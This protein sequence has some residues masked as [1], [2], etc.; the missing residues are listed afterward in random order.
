MILIKQGSNTLYEVNNYTYTESDMGDANITLKLSVPVNM[1]VVELGKPEVDVLAP[2]F[3]LDWFVEEK[4]EKFYLTTEKP[5]GTKST[6]S[7]NYVY[8]LIFNSERSALKKR[9][10]K[11]LASL[12][13]DTFISQGL[14]FNLMNA[15]LS[16]FAQLIQK[17]L[18]DC[19]GSAWVIDIN[20]EIISSVTATVLIEISNTYIWDLLLKTYEYYGVRWTIQSINGVMTIRVGYDPVEISHIF[21]YG[22]ENG[23]TT[24]TRQITDTKV[25]NRLRGTGGTRNLPTNYFT[26][27]Y[28]NFEPDPDAIAGLFAFKNLMPKCFRDSVKL[29]NQDNTKP[30][31]DYVTLPDIPEY[32]VIEDG[33]DSNEDIYPSIEGVTIAGLGRIDEIVDVEQTYFDDPE[34]KNGIGITGVT[35]TADV[36][37]GKTVDN[38]TV[39]EKYTEPFVITDAKNV[40]CDLNLQFLDQY[41]NIV[42]PSEGNNHSYTFTDKTNKQIT[43]SGTID[44]I[45]VSAQL[46]R[47]SD[48]AVVQTDTITAI[49]TVKHIQYLNLAIGSYKIKVTTTA[50]GNLSAKPLNW[51]AFG[52]KWSAVGIVTSITNVQGIYKSTFDIW[53]KDI[54]FDLAET[55]TDGISKYAGT[56]DGLITFKSG[57]LAG[58]D[59]KIMKVS[60]VSN[61]FACYPDTS[62]SLDGVQSKY[63][64]TLIKNDTEYQAGSLMLPNVAVRALPADQFAI[65]DINMP[66]SYVTT[67]EARLQSYLEEQLDIISKLYPTYTV[68]LLDIFLQLNPTIA[69]DLRGG[70]KCRIQDSRLTTGDMSLYIN[71]VTI[72][73]TGILPKYT[74]TVTDKIT[75]NGSTVQRISAQIDAISAGIYTG[76]LSTAMTVANLDKRFLRKNIEDTAYEEIDFKGGLKAT[77]I[78][79]EDFQQ[80]QFAGKGMGVFKDLSGETVIEVD[81][82]TVRNTATFNEVVINQIKFQGGIVVYSLANMEVSRVDGMTLYFDMKG[83]SVQNQ[84]VLDD[85]VRCQRWVSGV[86]TKDY[87][88]IVTDVGVDYIT[89][90]SQV[91]QGTIDASVGDIV[92][93]FGNI[94]N[95]DRR[96]AIEVNVLNGGRQTFYQDLGVNPLLPFDTTNKNVIDIGNVFDTTNQFSTTNKWR[97]VI[98]VYGDAY[99]GAR[100]MSSY[101][102]FNKDGELEIKAN[103]L[104]KGL[105]GEYKE[106]S[107]IDASYLIDVIKKGTSEI[108]GGLALANV[109]AVKD[110]NGNITAGI[111][112]VQADVFSIWSGGTYSQAKAG[113]AKV[114]INKDG[115]GYLADHNISW[116]AAG[117]LIMKYAF[118]ATEG[119]IGNFTIFEN[120]IVND[121]IEFSDTEI[122]SL[123]SLINPVDE[124]INRVASWTAT[125]IHYATAFTQALTTTK[126]GLV[127]VAVFANIDGA[128]D[129]NIKYPPISS[130]F[131]MHS[132]EFKLTVWISNE[133]NETVITTSKLCRDDGCASIEIAPVLPAGVYIIHALAE[134]F[135]FENTNVEIIGNYDNATTGAIIFGGD[136]NVI[137]LYR[138]NNNT[139]IGLDGFYSELDALR[140]FYFKATSGLKVKGAKRFFNDSYR[141][142]VYDN[143]LEPIISNVN[144]YTSFILDR[145]SN[146]STSLR[147][148]HL[149]A[150][151]DLESGVNNFTLKILIGSSNG[152]IT[153]IDQKTNSHFYDDNGNIFNYINMEIGDSI[154][155]RAVREGD[156]MRYFLI[157]TGGEIH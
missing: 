47:V 56:D 39:S 41:D 7:L 131:T 125:G 92:V 145:Y 108:T 102:R 34:Y 28:S 61:V 137:G 9:M 2:V 138:P 90:S 96:S 123:D 141:G 121:S 15:N 29:Y 53:V 68:E 6:S 65:L 82:L 107:D 30:L 49:D 8:D 20:P 101:L 5:Q 147:I 19:F 142:Y 133:L 100:D 105:D 58:Y 64:I 3:G 144:S 104:F 10:V 119:Y 122:E 135:K 22:S 89:L 79:T 120:A 95:P 12:S 72:E 16:V 66:H 126:A 86:Q 114:I 32:S 115:S 94:S 46:I 51:V 116:D 50:K 84:F 70:N 57:M 13:P 112:G 4:G 88:S 37:S 60:T 124:V 52:L 74:I 71:S 155:L 44:E 14:V 87:M 99:I 127:D 85:I 77:T 25:V 63:R 140:Y 152:K 118:K 48:N 69:D 136:P 156:E 113:T 55:G 78:K 109:F 91:T 27:R 151:T 1:Q 62:R 132:G 103:I 73:H 129:P 67:A 128:R 35:S 11:D 75:V 80:G 106:M 31:I 45:S 81:K 83:G 149:P 33:L 139:K 143:N 18:T 42:A 26:S 148:I 59:F 24:I 93:Q 17:N 97:N 23:L 110:A 36:Y 38:L 134:N 150:P 21:E 98:R 157:K 117:N 153:R 146:D 54:Q 111:S 154:E 130:G 76:Q 43:I 40:I